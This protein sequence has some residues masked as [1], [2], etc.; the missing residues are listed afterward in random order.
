M[1]LSDQKM[2]DCLRETSNEN[3]KL[4]QLN[5]NLFMRRI[6]IN[7]ET[8]LHRYDPETKQTLGSS[9]CKHHYIGNMM[10]TVF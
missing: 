10:C 8:W 5:W 9:S 3:L 2:K 4:M 7:D 6:V 1:G